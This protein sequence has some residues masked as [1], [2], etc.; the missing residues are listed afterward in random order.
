MSSRKTTY[1]KKEGNRQEDAEFFNSLLIN[2][3]LSNGPKPTIDD[4]EKKKMTPQ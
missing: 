1:S 3:K 4:P 2:Y